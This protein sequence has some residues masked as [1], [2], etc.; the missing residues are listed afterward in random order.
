M[1][2]MVG[3]KDRIKYQGKYWNSV[4]GA[5]QLLLLGRLTWELTAKPLKDQEEQENVYES[6]CFP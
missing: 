2:I 6:I 1:D 3:D 5:F 4:Y